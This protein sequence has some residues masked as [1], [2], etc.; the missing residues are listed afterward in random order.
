[1][2]SKFDSK[3]VTNYYFYINRENSD[4]ARWQREY[5]G[6]KVESSSESGEYDSPHNIYSD[7]SSDP[8]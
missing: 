1:M 6:K 3:H 7:I 2:N 4:N 8:I 5:E